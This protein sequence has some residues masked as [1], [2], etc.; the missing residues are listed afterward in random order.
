ML[1]SVAMAYVGRLSRNQLATVNG[2][3]ADEEEHGVEVGEGRGLGRS[4]VNLCTPFVSSESC[5]ES[6]VERGYKG[7]AAR[8]PEAGVLTFPNEGLKRL[9]FDF[10]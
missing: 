5:V 2:S 1:A 7:L 10:P 9:D 8:Y 3:A 6:F 4:R